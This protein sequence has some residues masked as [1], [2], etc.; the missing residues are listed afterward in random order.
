MSPLNE[1]IKQEV[2]EQLY[3]DGE[4]WAFESMDG[5]TSTQFKM[6]DDHYKKAL[7]NTAGKDAFDRSTKEGDAESKAYDKWLE[8]QARPDTMDAFTDIGGGEAPPSIDNDYMEDDE[9]SQDRQRRRQRSDDN[10]EDGPEKDKENDNTEDGSSDKEKPDESNEAPKKEKSP[11]GETPPKEP[12]LG[13]PVG[14][15]GKPLG[16]SGGATPKPPVGAGAGGTGAAGGTAAGGAGATGG[17][18]AAGGA[19]AGGAAAGEAVAVGGTAAVATSEV[20][21]PILIIIIV[22]LLL[23]FLF[24]II[25][26][27]FG[28]KATKGPTGG[29]VCLDPGHPPNGAGGEPELNLKVAKEVQTELEARGYTVIMTRTTSDAVA[30]SDRPKICN[31]RAVS[32]GGADLF[33][34]FHADGTPRSAGYPYQIYPKSS[35]TTISSKSKD[36]AEKIQKEVAKSV[37]GSGG[38]T[39][40]GICAEAA[41]TAVKDLAV[42]SGAEKYGIPAVLTEM[43]QLHSG[44]STLDDAAVRKKLVVGIA[45][46]IESVVAKEQSP[47]VSGNAIIDEAKK[48]IGVPYKWGGTTTSGFDCSGFTQYVYKHAVSKNIPRVSR[49]QYSNAPIKI[50]NKKDLQ[51]GDLVFFKNPIGHVGIYI[52]KDKTRDGRNVNDAYIHSPQTGDSVKISSLGDRSDFAGGGRYK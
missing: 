21:L 13:E 35:R 8:K 9:P 46:G 50:S 2:K 5:W 51:P 16:A 27:K 19:A 31:T 12:K 25:S 37:S 3:N 24:F 4:R 34:S 30:L 45:N 28:S 32:K 47:G 17:A 20:W 42:F 29:V 44:S 40:G 33:Y 14:E 10:D 1:R 6:F 52:G 48:H 7:K 23:L 36:M 39:D 43:V 49:A 26:V 38:L 15:G 22:V 18:A 41:C 11:D